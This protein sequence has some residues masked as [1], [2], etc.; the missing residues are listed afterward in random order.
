[1]TKFRTGGNG[2]P[3][4]GAESPELI[5]PPRSAR[6][7]AHI[8]ASALATTR[9]TTRRIAEVGDTSAGAAGPERDADF[10]VSEDRRDDALARR[11]GT[12]GRRRRRFCDDGRGAPD[13]RIR[14]P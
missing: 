8:D 1:M 2:A 4:V 10:G 11:P 12:P 13:R 14:P 9:A 6:A 3:R 5:S 7:L